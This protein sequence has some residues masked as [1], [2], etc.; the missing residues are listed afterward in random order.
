MMCNHVKYEWLQ[1]LQ[2]SAAPV[3]TRRIQF[4]SAMDEAQT[5]R[6]PYSKQ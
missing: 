5:I 4:F 2:L 6:A 3:I 1:D